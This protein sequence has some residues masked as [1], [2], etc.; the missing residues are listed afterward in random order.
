MAQLE[1]LY[2]AGMFSNEAEEKLKAACQVRG[3]GM[4]EAGRR[5]RLLPEP[6]L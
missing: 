4:H 2:I 6:F 5:I 1:E 3:I